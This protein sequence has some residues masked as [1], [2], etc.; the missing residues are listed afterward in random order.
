MKKNRI[1]TEYALKVMRENYNEYR[2][3]GEPDDPTTLREYVEAQADS[4]PAFFG[5]LF[6]DDDIKDFGTNLTDDQK[7][8]YKNFLD[9][10]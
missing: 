2:R 6:S 3:S 1:N 4:D 7:E 5:W 10:L 8:E 9:E